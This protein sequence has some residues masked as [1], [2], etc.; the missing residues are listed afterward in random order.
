MKLSVK[1]GLL[2]RMSEEIVACVGRSLTAGLHRTAGP[3]IYQQQDIWSL[4]VRSVHIVFPG[5]PAGL[6]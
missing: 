3:D 1:N 5:H 2:S 4:N 6:M